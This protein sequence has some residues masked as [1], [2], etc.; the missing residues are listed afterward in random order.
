M[1][2]VNGYT[3]NLSLLL[4][5]KLGLVCKLLVSLFL[6]NYTPE[7]MSEKFCLKSNDFYLN[8]SKSFGK[9]RNVEQS[10]K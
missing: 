10:L 2:N 5:V 6:Y 1:F 4:Y 3:N 7:K 8:V 9:L